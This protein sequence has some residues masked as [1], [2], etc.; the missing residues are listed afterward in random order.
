MGEARSV[1]EFSITGNGTRTSAAHSDVGCSE[2]KA[3]DDGSPAGE[4]VTLAR[5]EGGLKNV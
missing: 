3:S 4:G 5:A 2:A 1:S